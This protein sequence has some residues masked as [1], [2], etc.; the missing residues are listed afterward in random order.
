MG[1]E[2]AEGRLAVNPEEGG[3]IRLIYRWHIDGMEPKSDKLDEPRTGRRRTTG[4][5]SS[6]STH[7]GYHR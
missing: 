7:L 2:A 4:E 3:I 1:S 5:S 6:S